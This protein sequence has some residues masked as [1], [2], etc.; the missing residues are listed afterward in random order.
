MILLGKRDK[1]GCISISFHS[2]T[3]IPWLFPSISQAPLQQ[4]LS[5]C[6]PTF[7]MEWGI[8]HDSTLVYIYINT[9]IYI[10]I[11][12]SIINIIY[13]YICI[14]TTYTFLYVCVLHIFLFR[15]T[16]WGLHFPWPLTSLGHLAWCSPG[17]WIAAS[18]RGWDDWDSTTGSMFLPSGYVKNSYGKWPFIVSFPTKHGDFPVRYV[19]RERERCIYIYAIDHWWLVRILMGLN[20]Q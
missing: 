10:Y 11:Y 1:H 7:H 14:I 18:R 4:N 16:S 20:N 12:M 2:P 8:F 17:R 13:I 9:Y 19:E 5:G 15:G 3:F 6:Q